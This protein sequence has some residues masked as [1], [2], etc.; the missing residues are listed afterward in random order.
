[1]GPWSAIEYLRH[2]VCKYV[3]MFTCC[4]CRID[5]PVPNKNVHTMTKAASFFTT[6]L[7]SSEAEIPTK[8]CP[9]A[10]NNANLVLFQFIQC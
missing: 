10:R 5:E 1:M 9:A 3:R 2:Q 8:M 6:K 7:E 4:K